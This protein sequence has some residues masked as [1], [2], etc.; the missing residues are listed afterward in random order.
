MVLSALSTMAILSGCSKSDEAN[1]EGPTV[2]DPGG[3][4]GTWVL[5]NTDGTQDWNTGLY[6]RDDGYYYFFSNPGTHVGGRMWVANNKVYIRNNKRLGYL[7]YLSDLRVY[8]L[9]ELTPGQSFSYSNENG[10]SI[11]Y[12][13]YQEEHPFGDDQSMEASNNFLGRYVVYNSIRDHY[14]IWELDLCDPR[15]SSGLCLYQNHPTFFQSLSWDVK[16]GQ[17]Q[18]SS[19]FSN[20]TYNIENFVRGEGFNAG[21]YSLTYYDGPNRTLPHTLR[22]PSQAELD[23]ALQQELAITYKAN[24]SAA[25]LNQA[26]AVFSSMMDDIADDIRGRN[27]RY[28]YF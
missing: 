28:D 23:A 11:R 21:P 12:E 26:M 14:E 1:T 2:L 10:V 13:F 24:A 6:V 27:Y 5:L 15:L 7:S 25:Q 17:L 9:L 22:M 4:E 3:I 16:N 20:Y 8:D 19:P 18:I